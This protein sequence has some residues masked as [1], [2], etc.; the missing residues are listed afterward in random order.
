MIQSN[1][2][3]E[4]ITSNG[5]H[6]DYLKV[7]D[8]QY[9]TDNRGQK[10]AATSIS[11]TYRMQQMTK[12]FGVC[13]HGWGWEVVDKWVDDDLKSVFAEV[14]VW[15]RLTPDGEK[16]WTGSQIGG[17]KAGIRNTD[18]T[19]KMSITDALGKAF[20]ALGLCADVYLGDFDDCK[21]VAEAESTHQKRRTAEREHLFSKQN[22]LDGLI[23][24]INSCKTLEQV[25][26]IRSRCVNGPAPKEWYS[27]LSIAFKA[28]R[29]S[30][31]AESV[32]GK[33]Q[34]ETDAPAV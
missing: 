15:T 7:T 27:D 6:W 16:G 24:Q 20:V 1:E 18:E 9:T 4:T 26:S 11:I 31:E 32:E 2:Q 19:Y 22:S 28:A 23:E 5:Q 21:Y 29:K 17:T 13:G 8:K 3:I 14:R 34:E 33:A 12:A 30:I 10:F 25:D